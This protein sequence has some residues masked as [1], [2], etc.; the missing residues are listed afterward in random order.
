MS[1]VACQRLLPGPSEQQHHVAAPHR[2][3]APFQPPS[4]PCPP[5]ACRE[6]AQPGGRCGLSQGPRQPV[7][8]SSRLPAGGS[9][10]RHARPRGAGHSAGGRPCTHG[11]SLLSGVGHWRPSCSCGGLAAPAGGGAPRGSGSRGRGAATGMRQ[12]ACA[13]CGAASPMMSP[14]LVSQREFV[15]MLSAWRRSP[16]LHTR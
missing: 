6:R 16:L 1:V 5:T 8:P 10:G 12:Q 14:P 15:T 7:R 9:C 11:C 3:Q 2:M 4:C 13:C